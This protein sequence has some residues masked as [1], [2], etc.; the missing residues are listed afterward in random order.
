MKHTFHFIL[1]PLCN[2]TH[3]HT[4]T[5]LR[6]SLRPYNYQAALL[7]LL[8]CQFGVKWLFISNPDVTHIHIYQH[9]RKVIG[10]YWKNWIIWNAT[11]CINL[12]FIKYLLLNS[13]IDLAHR[14]PKYKSEIFIL[15]ILVSR[16]CSHSRHFNWSLSIHHIPT[17]IPRNHNTTIHKH[18]EL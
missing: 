6:V 13:I 14:P 10:A 5:M 17:G 4:H 16:Y 12:W 15:V 2:V 1:Q 3:T 9:F 8:T 11:W 7:Q 18:H